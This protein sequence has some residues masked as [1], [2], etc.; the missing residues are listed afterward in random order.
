MIERVCKLI[1]MEVPARNAGLLF[2][3]GTSVPSTA[4]KYQTGCIFAKTNGGAGTALYV[5][6]GT[7]A[8]PSFQAISALTAAQEEL[9]GATAGTV[10]ASKFVIVDAYK[11]LRWGGF[12]PSAALT[13]AVPFASVPDTWSDGQLDILAVFGGT[14]ADLTGLVS[15]KCGRFRHVVNFSGTQNAEIYGLVGQVVAKTVVLGLFSAGLMG[16][17]ESNG[18]FHAGDGGSSNPVHAGV[19]G[20]PGG[21][22]ITVDTGAVLAAVAALSN[23]SSVTNNGDYAG[24]YIG[25]CQDSCDAF[26]VGLLIAGSASTTAIEVGACTTGLSITGATGYAVDIQTSGV[27]RMG[28]QDTGVDLTTAYPFGMEIHTEANANIVSGDTGS[29]AGIYSRYAVESAQTSQTNHI[30]I[31]GKLR[32]KANLGDGVHA[33]VYGAVEISAGTISGTATTQ[34]CAAHF[35]L[36]SDP[37]NITTG[38]YNGV[39]VDSSVATGGTMNA[40]MSGI[41]IKKSGSALAWSVGIQVEGSSSTIGLQVGEFSASTAGSGVTVNNT[42]NRAAGFYA[43]DNGVGTAGAEFISVLRGRLL[44]TGATYVGEQYGLHGTVTYKPASSAALSSWTAG[45]LGTFEGATAMVISGGIHGA[46]IGRVGFGAMQPSGAGGQICGICALN[47]MAAELGDGYTAAFVADSATAIDWTWGLKINNCVKAFS[48][49]GACV[50]AHSAGSAASGKQILIDV[51]G[52]AY[53]LALCAVG[54]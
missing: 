27:F 8:S 22:S 7:Y 2:A 10:T 51:D 5:N 45:V 12:N 36:E 50:D 34:T 15:A 18:G 40:T 23:T 1:K 49:N 4:N 44:C 52:G 43:D 46:I 26:P 11:T 30:A 16:T 42:N 32:V 9:L 28:V 39:V 3:S 14:G 37:T 53:A 35:A 47:N 41:R 17:I 25:R 31:F 6:E 13:D 24:V 21:S 54:G 48:F 33:A 38:H 29:S 20:R 19:I